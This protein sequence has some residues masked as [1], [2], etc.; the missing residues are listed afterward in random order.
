[1]TFRCLSIDEAGF[2]VTTTDQ[3]KIHHLQIDGQGRSPGLPSL[4]E[5]ITTTYRAAIWLAQLPGFPA[6]RPAEEKVDDKS[7]WGTSSGEDSDEVTDMTLQ[8]SQDEE[9][10]EKEQGSQDMPTKGWIGL[11]T[12]R[13]ND[14]SHRVIEMA[15]GSVSAIGGELQI[16][17]ELTLIDDTESANLP[18][19][20][21]G[22]LLSD[23]PASSVRL[24]Q[25]SLG[26]VGRDVIMTRTAW[27]KPAISWSRAVLPLRVRRR[28]L[29]KPRPPPAAS[30]TQE[31]GESDARELL[32]LQQKE[33]VFLKIR[34]TLMTSSFRTFDKIP[35]VHSS[36]SASHRYTP[37]IKEVTM[38]DEAALNTW[39]TWL[40]K[41]KKTVSS[42]KLQKARAPVLPPMFRN[43]ISRRKRGKAL[44]KAILESSQ[45]ISAVRQHTLPTIKDSSLHGDLQAMLGGSQELRDMCMTDGTPLQEHK[46]ITIILDALTSAIERVMRIF[47]QLGEGLITTPQVIVAISEATTMVLQATTN[48]KDYETAI[49][50]ATDKRATMPSLLRRLS[51]KYKHHPHHIHSIRIWW[52]NI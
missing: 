46:M 11:N 39:L 37:K 9:I 29:E 28:A 23:S 48:Y 21:V 25:V 43:G 1:V 33:S 22:V 4:R 38:K 31:R 10:S 41:D 45:L 40:N 35:R 47:L 5:A 6:A 36:V 42:L 20:S 51:K 27:D 17:E 26:G 44:A 19:E 8:N 18:T 24:N 3:G 34:K 50:T 7:A 15:S 30:V 16:G 32:E 2:L 13:L 52:E 14:G 12:I 49:T